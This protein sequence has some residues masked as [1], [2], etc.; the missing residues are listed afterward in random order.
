MWATPALPPTI[1]VSWRHVLLEQVPCKTASTELC[2]EVQCLTIFA[3]FYL[4][5]NYLCQEMPLRRHLQ[6]QGLPRLT[7][8]L[9][10]LHFEILGTG[11]K[12]LCEQPQLFRMYSLRCPQ[13]GT[14]W[15]T[16]AASPTPGVSWRGYLV[17][18]L[19]CQSSLYSTVRGGT[20][21]DH[22][23]A[24]ERTTHV[25]NCIYRYAQVQSI[26]CFPEAL[27]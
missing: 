3:D 20:V 26:M 8:A 5:E 22:L 27:C 16:L 12:Q 18:Q 19:P 13:E 17:G 15:V 14:V 24:C 25:K 23:L 9:C 11:L 1:I 21:F 4:S 6:T 7:K 10:E 2:D